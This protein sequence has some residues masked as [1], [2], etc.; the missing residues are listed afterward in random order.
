[1]AF[2]ATD[3]SARNDKRMWHSK[4]PS[5]LYKSSDQS[6]YISKG[7]LLASKLDKYTVWDPAVCPM[8]LS[9]ASVVLVVLR[10]LRLSNKDCLVW[11]EGVYALCKYEALRQ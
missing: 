8:H 11:H 10:L 7:K 2:L 4:E 5:P 9:S 1:M 3:I 6:F